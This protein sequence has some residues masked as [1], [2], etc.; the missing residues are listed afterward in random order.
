[1]FCISNCVYGQQKPE[2]IP[3]RLIPTDYYPDDRLELEIELIYPYTMENMVEVHK[4]ETLE[5]VFER[6]NYETIH[7]EQSNQLFSIDGKLYYLI[8]IPY[9]GV[10]WNEREVK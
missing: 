5:I 1:M 8:R 10:V 4:E 9:T 6:I 3:Y 2:M 7:P